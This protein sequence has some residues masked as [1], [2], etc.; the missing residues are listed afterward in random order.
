LTVYPNFD[1]YCA[2]Q[3]REPKLS[4]HTLLQKLVEQHLSEIK[5]SYTKLRTVADSK[6]YNEYSITNEE[7]SSAMKAAHTIR[8]FVK[9]RM[10]QS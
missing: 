2:E 3:P 5:S 9:R 6:R 1:E 7:V 4:K 8:N 10:N